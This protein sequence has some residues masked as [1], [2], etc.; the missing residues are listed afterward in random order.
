MYVFGRFDGYEVLGDRIAISWYK[1][2][3]KAHAYSKLCSV[4]SAD[5]S[6]TFIDLVFSSFWI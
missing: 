6:R 4:V 1:D 3:R 5:K 2:V